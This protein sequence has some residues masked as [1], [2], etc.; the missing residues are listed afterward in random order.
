MSDSLLDD[1]AKAIEDGD[2]FQ[3]ESLLASG[4]IDVNARLPRELNPPPLVLA[5]T[6][7]ACRVAIV[8]M[9]LSAGA[10]IDGVDDN[11][12]TACFVAVWAHNVDALA[13]LL[14]H[15]PDLEIKD[16]HFNQTP[17]QLSLEQSSFRSECISVILINA[18]AALDVLPGSLFWFASRSTSAI[19]ALLNRNFV[20]SQLRSRHNYTPLHAIAFE[21]EWSAS[22]QAAA[23]ML[24]NVCGVDLEARSF[25]DYTCTQIAAAGRHGA[26]RCFIDAGADVNAAHDTGQTPLHRVSNYEC[27]V[28][29]L[30]GGADVNKRNDRGQTASQT[31]W[32]GNCFALFLAAGADPNDINGEIIVDISARQLETARRDI[33]KARLDFVRHRAWQVCISLQS[34]GLDAL[35]MCEILLHACG[36]VAPLIAFHQWWKIATTVKHFRN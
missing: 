33:A 24:I 29:L 32:K 26:L 19:Q 22:L 2:S 25:D 15:R 17:L 13:V 34:R 35:Q 5:V 31:L 7:E 9:L 16:S 30:A 23:N 18:G 10:H 3:V 36:P 27:A 12:Q 21:H 1:F 11:G 14:A 6:C 8:E 20:V 4:S 28:L